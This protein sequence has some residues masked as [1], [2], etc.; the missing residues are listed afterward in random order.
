ME[1]GQA[2][3]RVLDETVVSSS[4]L[5]KCEKSGMTITNVTEVVVSSRN[6]CVGVHKLY[7]GRGCIIT[8]EG[9]DG[10][11]IWMSI[12]VSFDD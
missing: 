5:S 11:S 12:I 9:W 6:R 2:E 8:K 7:G 3:E 10:E 1:L 4:R